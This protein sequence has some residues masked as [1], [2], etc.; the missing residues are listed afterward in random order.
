MKVNREY[1]Q[2]LM[3]PYPKMDC[4]VDVRHEGPSD[5][6]FWIPQNSYGSAKDAIEAIDSFISIVSG[7]GFNMKETPEGDRNSVHVDFEHED[8]RFVRLWGMHFSHIDGD[9][10]SQ[11]I[12]G[13]LKETYPMTEEETPDES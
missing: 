4:K 12:G 1:L 7:L 13:Y 5:F 6:A 3:A 11:E 8:G 2:E 10:Y 9:N